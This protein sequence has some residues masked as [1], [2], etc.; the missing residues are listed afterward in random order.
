MKYKYI[1][2]DLDGTLTDPFEGITTCFKYALDYY[3]ISAEQKDLTCVIGPP[4]ID[5][6]CKFFDFDEEDP[7]GTLEKIKAEMQKSG[8]LNSLDLKCWA[9]VS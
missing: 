5:S 7:H 9:K 1:L 2:F 4:L 6:F 8:D 3:G